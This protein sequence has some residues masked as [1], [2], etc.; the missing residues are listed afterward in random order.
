MSGAGSSAIGAALRAT[1]MQDVMLIEWAVGRALR[2]TMFQRSAGVF[3]RGR[4]ANS[5]G[6]IG[7][8]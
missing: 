7:T 8:D 4:G 2:A 5:T 3:P 1:P 6:E